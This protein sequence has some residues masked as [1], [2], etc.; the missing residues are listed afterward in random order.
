MPSPCFLKICHGSIAHVPEN[1]QLGN[2][3][4]TKHTSAPDPR[5][6]T[7]LTP[8][9]NHCPNS[10]HTDGY[11]RFINRIMKWAPLFWPSLFIRTLRFSPQG[12]GSWG[13]CTL[14]LYRASHG[15]NGL[16][17]CP[18]SC[19]WA[20]GELPVWGYCGWCGE[21]RPPSLD[22]QVCDSRGEFAHEWLYSL[23]LFY[24]GNAAY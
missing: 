17:M 7:F 11:A 10:C 15:G 8:E 6:V 24:K 3:S 4:L 5:R 19:W 1:M 20:F 9:G 16:H 13:R 23:H 2:F 12:G 22:E 21:E 14:W 18:S